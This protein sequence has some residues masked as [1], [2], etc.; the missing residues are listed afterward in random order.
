MLLAIWM[1]PAGRAFIGP[2]PPVTPLPT[3]LMATAEFA[4]PRILLPFG[5]P[6]PPILILDAGPIPVLAMTGRECPIRNVSPAT[7]PTTPPSKPIA[8]AETLPP[9][10]ALT[11]GFCERGVSVMAV[12]ELGRQQK[13]DNADSRGE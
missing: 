5:L 2:L 12:R 13:K 3:P 9:S 10:L 1:A 11:S 7:S 8:P 4:V 6:D